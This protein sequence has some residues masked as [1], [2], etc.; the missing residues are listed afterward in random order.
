MADALPWRRDPHSTSNWNSERAPELEQNPFT[1]L[2]FPDV[3]PPPIRHDGIGLGGQGRNLDLMTCVRMSWVFPGSQNLIQSA[4][5]SPWTVLPCA[6][7]PA[8]PVSDSR[9]AHL[10]PRGYKGWGNSYRWENGVEL[11]F[12][13]LLLAGR[14]GGGRPILGRIW[15]R[16]VNRPPAHCFS[17]R[18]AISQCLESLRGTA[19]SH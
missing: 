18:A 16:L 6:I 17:G 1:R 15:G 9:L 8:P 12:S 11:S 13:C 3:G 2:D 19:G 10:Q 4:A 14:R 7:T 5:L